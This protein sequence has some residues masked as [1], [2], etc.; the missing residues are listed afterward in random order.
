MP[1]A[2]AALLSNLA[3]APLVTIRPPG[4]A[5]QEPAQKKRLS[6]NGAR[7]TIGFDE[8]DFERLTLLSNEKLYLP[9]AASAG[10]LFKRH[11]ARQIP[12][13]QA[14]PLSDLATAPLM[15]IRP[16]GSAHQRPIQTKRLSAKLP[17]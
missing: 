16:T 9:F 5:D 17:E 11:A 4:S 7:L 15:A 14:L 1:F 2:V 10:P 3:T 8:T 6:A 12:F 13:A